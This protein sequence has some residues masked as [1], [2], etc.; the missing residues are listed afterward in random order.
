MTSPL[1]RVRGTGLFFSFDRALTCLAH[2]TG[3]LSESHAISS[4][5][6]PFLSRTRLFHFPTNQCSPLDI[7]ET[8]VRPIQSYLPQTS[9]FLLHFPFI[10]P[11]PSPNVPIQSRSGSKCTSS[12]DKKI[13]V[14]VANLKQSGVELVDQLFHETL[15]LLRSRRL[16]YST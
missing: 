2:Y 5:P 3:E 4:F 13:I 7:K 1:S 14:V 15:A 11:P 9:S 6:F 12:N 16:R 8:L 10:P